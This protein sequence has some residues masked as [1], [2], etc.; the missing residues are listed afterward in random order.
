MSLLKS[1]FK[2]AKPFV[3]AIPGIGPALSAGLGVG[4]SL[5]KGKEQKGAQNANA[6]IQAQNAAALEKRF[7]TG[8]DDSMA[9]LR[10]MIGETADINDDMSS[11]IAGYNDDV[12]SSRTSAQST[13]DGLL[14]EIRN[15]GV[16]IKDIPDAQEFGY[17]DQVEGADAQF[18]DIAYEEDNSDAAVLRDRAAARSRGEADAIDA[19]ILKKQMMT[20]AGQRGP[21]ADMLSALI[22]KAGGT[23]I[24]RS[25]EDSG[26]RAAT[27]LTRTGGSGA[28]TFANL[29]RERSAALRDNDTNAILAGIQ[30]AEDMAGARASRLNPM[31]AALSA[32]GTAMP[33]A[34]AEMQGKALR[35]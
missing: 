9:E 1:L 10:R 17:Q 7:N 18:K 16:D 5:L 31:I 28:K 30:G 26:N 19:N 3:G 13:I 35:M 14:N 32:R 2:I 25:F 4:S 23:A 27:E 34:S 8:R 15:S 29:A 21:T 22:A 11:Q 33:D 24:S 20:E 12:K 6:A